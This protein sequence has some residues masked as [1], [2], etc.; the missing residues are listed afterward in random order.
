MGKLN[1]RTRPVESIFRSGCFREAHKMFF[2]VLNFED[3][4][5]YEDVAAGG[6]F[7]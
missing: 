6:G 3:E 7:G 2:N 5:G 1:P 4:N